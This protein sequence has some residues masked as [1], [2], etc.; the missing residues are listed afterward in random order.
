MIST[1]LPARVWAKA[2]FGGVRLSDVRRERR[3]VK[4]A[5][6]LALT[7]SGTLPGALSGWAELKGAYRLLS[8]PDVS[9]DKLMS[10]HW[11]KTAAACRESGEFLLVEDTT[12]LDF[13]THESTD[14]LGRIGND[15][16]RGLHLHST[17]ALRIESWD[18]AQVP[19]VTIVGLLGQQW[20]ARMGPPRKKDETSQERLARSRESE[21]WAR[22]FEGARPSEAARW[23]YVAD[24]E[25]DIYEVFERC[26]SSAVGLL[27]RACRPRTLEKENGSVFDAVAQAPLLGQFTLD[28]RAR[29]GASTRT[30]RLEVRAKTVTLRGPKRP[31]RQPDP[32][33]VNVVEAREIKAPS[34]AE[35]I[36]WVVLTSW[37]CATFAEARRAIGAYSRRWLIEEYHKALKTGVGIEKSQLTSA[38]QITS[39][40]GILG[41]IALRLLNT[42]LLAAAR[43]DERIAPECFDAG[44]LQILE[45]TSKKPPKGWTHRTI[46]I[47]IARLGGF[48]A[49]KGDGDPG[50]ITIWRG[51]QRVSLMAAGFDAAMISQRCG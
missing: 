34:G 19:A 32:I 33:S 11:E 1:L 28:L 5:S 44:T 4:L 38:A 31:G 25:S 22:V 39:L 41:V 48:L 9:Y 16:G 40:L 12:S 21:R 3:L 37:P 2:E 10:P 29:P 45:T 23:T 8:N 35:P 42:K 30:A 51:W 18:D 17:L 27:V 15:S 50:W 6:A 26:S 47:A 36:H 24:R 46:L 14:D 13:T 43:P 7:P 20:W 49:R